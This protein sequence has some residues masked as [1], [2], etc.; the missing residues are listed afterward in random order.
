MAK[1]KPVVV[2]DTT[3]EITLSPTLQK[4]LKH[5]GVD[6]YA[7]FFDANGSPNWTTLV[8]NGAIQG[9]GVRDVVL[10]KTVNGTFQ[11]MK[12][13]K[14]YILIGSGSDIKTAVK[15]Q[16]DINWDNAKSHDF[17]YDSLEVTL[18][19]SADDKAN[20]TSI[21]GFGLPMQL[22]VPYEG[23]SSASVGYKIDASTLFTNL[24]SAATQ[25]TAVDKYTKGPLKGQDRMAISPTVAL[26]EGL[27]N[28][29]A[30]DWDAYIDILKTSNG[31][32]V[33]SG[34][35]NGAPDANGIYHN[36]GYY[37]YSLEWSTPESVFWLTPEESS[38]IKGD[39]Q[40]TE[41]DLAN[42]IYSTLGNAGVYNGG[43][44]AP[45]E[46]ENHNAIFNSNGY[47][48]TMN[49]GEN[50]QWG[51]VLAQFITGFTGGY[52]GQKANSINGQDTTEIDLNTNTNW[53]P[54]YA[55][56]EYTASGAPTF[57]DHYSQAFFNI[58]NSYGSGYSDALMSQY[59]E[60]GP[61]ISVSE[62]NPADPKNVPTLKL[63]IY[64]D[65]ETPD[66]YTP[67]K[68]YNYVA[69][70]G[71]DYTSSAAGDTNTSG[72]SVGF[73]F[74]NADMIL[75]DNTKITLEFYAGK[76]AK[77]KEIW[78]SVTIDPGTDSLW[79]Q[80]GITAANG[81]YSVSKPGIDKTEGYML[82]TNF[83]GVDA[84][85][86]WTRITV[87]EPGTAESKTFNLYTTTN[88]TEFVN[89]L[90][91]GQEGVLGVDGLATISPSQ[92]TGKGTITF[93]VNFMYSTTSTLPPELL[94]F[95]TAQNFA[96]PAA[97]VVGVIDHALFFG[98]EGQTSM[99]NP[100]ATAT[101]NAE[102][103][104]GWTGDN[105]FHDTNTINTKTWIEGYTNKIGAL[106]FA[107]VSMVKAGATTAATPLVTTADLDGAWTT[108]PTHVGNGTYVVTM[109]EYLASDTSQTSAIGKE[110]S[111]LTLTVDVAEMKLGAAQGGQALRLAAGNGAGDGIDGNWIRI[112][113]QET[114]SESGAA[115]AVVLTDA[116]GALVHARTGQTGDVSVEDATLTTV[117]GLSMQGGSG[118]K[119]AQSVY[120]PTEMHLRF[121]SLAAD[122][123]DSE[124]HDATVT[125][126]ANGKAVVQVGDHRLSAQVDNTLSGAALLADA[127]RQMGE[128]FVY[129][130][131]GQKIKVDLAGDA[132]GGNRMG[133]VRV[134][135]DA[136]D[137]SWSVGGVEHGKRGFNAAV[138]DSM[139]GEFLV[140]GR[141]TFETSDF[142]TVTG[143][144]G[145]YTPVLLTRYGDVIFS[146]AEN[147]D[148]G[149]GDALRLMGQ[150]FF[151]F[152]DGAGT[153]DHD[154]LTARLT[155]LSPIVD[156]TLEGKSLVPLLMDDRAVV[157]AGD[158]FVSRL[159]DDGATDHGLTLLAQP[160][161]PAHLKIAGKAVF[162]G[163]DGVKI[164]G[165]PASVVV[166][167][168][169]KL[170]L[171]GDGDALHLSDGAGPVTIRNDGVIRGDIS[172]GTG[173]D[174]VRGSGV[175]DGEVYLRRGG[176]T[177]IGTDNDDVV[178]GKI[179]ADLMRGRKGDDTLLAGRGRDEAHG[180]A[181]DDL[182]HGRRKNDML[183]GGKG[184]DEVRGGRGNDD[185]RGGPGN[186]AV[187][188]GPG[189]DILNGGAGNDVL[190]GGAGADVFVLQLKNGSDRIKD[191]KLSRDSIDLSALDLA[192]A[193]AA[194]LVAAAMGKAGGDAI[195]LDLAD[196]GG[197]GS[198]RFNELDLDQASEIEFLF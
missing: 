140:R 137:G 128:P 12:A 179:G 74:Q 146:P 178:R 133:F 84:G 85:V 177:F 91:E 78:D 102:L 114:P 7:V 79:Q 95:N 54:T 24:Q 135:I 52:Y 97:P 93:D 166:K 62:P 5:P 4:T 64:D 142:W 51:A 170:V 153:R 188:G 180:G 30:S 189:N 28:Y 9:S 32:I 124:A 10:T 80:W 66:G 113:A 119:G 183:F 109:K 82:I 169:G 29:S 185:L 46:I 70:K 136:T 100:V 106:N 26:P 17:R 138:R 198:V 111:P 156:D 181:G 37:A 3:L 155:P 88:G 165:G 20:L 158:T 41:A 191:F 182:L 65:S 168:G 86:H 154:D 194:D 197:Q 15:K 144:T 48:A 129:V 39:I 60:G 120:L 92:V 151:A 75:K 87:G 22:E 193:E 61:L 35:F 19:N 25:G 150:N 49:T 127:Q 13:G 23:G 90:Y 112:G 110:S 21:D 8:A 123:W 162:H 159:P 145:Y 175:F 108:T 190:K 58:S 101:K 152:E 89:P 6:A 11:E 173:D 117:G 174:T 77:G 38:Q 187:Y 115:V 36:S 33:I 1:T 31:D 172:L 81:K 139:D 132:E 16:S 98:L 122:D 134:D 184:D 167:D 63:T 143:E 118:L 68:I 53:D 192:S 107:Q 56:G 149:D 34:F 72:A 18:Q 59:Q 96:T 45:F 121:I 130:Q 76:T 83:P 171:R 141:G 125:T 195:L 103:A 55:F 104:F 160:G 105:D 43:S 42:S 94:E 71:D 116:S 176:D 14:V 50:N 148:A 2:N 186:D 47:P 196:L 131:K 147:G 161:D 163:T 40:L 67:T 157:R 73:N 44:P 126:R 57:Y 27:D 99:T 69:P 164:D